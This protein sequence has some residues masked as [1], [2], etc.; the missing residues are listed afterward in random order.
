MTKVF[1]ELSLSVD[2]SMLFP[3]PFFYYCLHFH[4]C[5]DVLEINKRIFLTTIMF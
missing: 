2:E 1:V 4:S 5:S 3:G